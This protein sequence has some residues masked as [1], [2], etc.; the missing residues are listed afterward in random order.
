MYDTASEH[1]PAIAAAIVLLVVLWLI[2]R[3]LSVL[4]NR[5]I[6]WAVALD[7]VYRRA[8]AMTKLAAGLMLLSGAIHLALAQ[9]HEGI[10]GLLFVINGLGFVVLGV[11]A[12][13]TTWL[14]R[15]AILWLVATILA[16]VVWIIAGWETPD[17]IGI[18]CKRIEL[19]PL[20]P[21][22]RLPPP[23]RRTRPRRPR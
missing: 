13:F 17:Q 21:V 16:Y 12:F 8:S 1:A 2:P 23:A 15:P 4:A 20:G 22:L 19:A 7:D 6:R 9:S 14:R 3:T 10:T 11:A 5:G 18:A